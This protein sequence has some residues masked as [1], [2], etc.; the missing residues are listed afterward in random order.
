MEDHELPGFVKIGSIIGLTLLPISVILY[1][2]YFS[3]YAEAKDTSV[4][5]TRRASNTTETALLISY[6][7]FGIIG[8]CL[9]LLIPYGHYLKS[10]N[11]PSVVNTRNGLHFEVSNPEKNSIDVYDQIKP[12]NSYGTL[13]NKP[14]HLLPKSNKF[15]SGEDTFL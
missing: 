6:L 2:V 14:N 4:T 10:K 7:T 12:N 1:V 3:L 5:L 8:Y 9:C 13:K 15:G 11:D